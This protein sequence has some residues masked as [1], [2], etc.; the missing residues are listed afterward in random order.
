MP[1]SAA[2]AAPPDLRASS[3]GLGVLILLGLYTYADRQIIGLQAEPIR[4]QLM[5]GDAQFGLVQSAGA[6][7]V[8]ALAGY[9]VGGLAD[10]CDRRCVLAGCL[11]VWCIAVALCGLASSFGALLLASALVAAAEAG[12]LPIAYAV[13]P[14][15]F[16]GR[17][18]QTAN[19]AYVFLGRLSA[20]LVIVACGALLHGVEAWRPLLPD[21]LASL[22]GWRLALLATA[23][24]GLLLLPL[25]LRLPPMQR[26]ASAPAPLPPVG[27]TLRTRPAAFAAIFGGIGLLSLGAQAFGTFVPVAAARAWNLPPLQAGQGLGG[28]ALAGAV[29]ALAI[30]ALLA[31]RATASLGPGSAMAASAMALA[32]AAATA[33]AAPLASTAGLFYGLYGLGLAG[34]MTAVMLLPT[35]LQ[36]LCPGPVRVR[37]MSI[38]VG[39]SLVA[40]AAGPVLVG[41]WSDALGGTAQGLITAMAGVAVLSHALAAL[42]LA[43]GARHEAGAARHAAAADAERPPPRAA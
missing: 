22:P 19:S 24:P 35:A 40:G 14:E 3:W 15:W 33:A 39:C 30:T 10:R 41:A 25:V 18:R 37:L 5:L 31:R 8:T 42:L 20:G 38:F 28:A 27:A 26:L 43:W 23:L 1:P 36:P 11:A 13:I 29:A 9:A 6:G 32:A 2:A 4:Q 16:E 34:V 17:R 7:I 21:A 12:L